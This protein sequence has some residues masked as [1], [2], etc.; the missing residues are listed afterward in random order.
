MET[1]IP[2]LVALLAQVAPMITTSSAVASAVDAIVA[3][4]PVIA[5]TAPA[6]IATVKGIINTLR[7]KSVASKE[8]L[9]ALDVAEARIDA[10]YDE[11]LAAAKA[12]DKAAAEPSNPAGATTTG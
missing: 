12:E 10:D 3:L 9:D 1:I 7:G 4:A 2:T 11:A 6:L 8:Q 5:K